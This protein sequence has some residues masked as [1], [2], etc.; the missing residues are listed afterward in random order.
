M[1]LSCKLVIR[2][3]KNIHLKIEEK[4]KQEYTCPPV[5]LL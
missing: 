3:K 4:M 2:N 5:T 1:A